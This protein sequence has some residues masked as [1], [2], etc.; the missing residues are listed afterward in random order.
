VKSKIE[1]KHDLRQAIRT[2]HLA[3]DQIESDQ[4]FGKGEFGRE[5]TAALKQSVKIIEENLNFVASESV[6]S[7]S[8]S[9]T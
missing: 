3:L 8:L 1:N 2:L 6:R 7:D 4:L 5:K 9:T